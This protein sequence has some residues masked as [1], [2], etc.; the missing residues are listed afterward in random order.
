MNKA[1]RFLTHPDHPEQY[2]ILLTD[3]KYKDVMYRYGK[4][5][6]SEDAAHDRAT[7]NFSFEI[8]DAENFKKELLQKDAEFC[9]L[10][11]DILVDIIE[12]NEFKIGNAGKNGN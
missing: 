2:S 1:Y 11:G 9:N 12:K 8:E 6:L 3:G 4:I 5:S 7:L 10:I